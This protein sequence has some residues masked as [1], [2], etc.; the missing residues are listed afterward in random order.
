MSE[1]SPLDEGRPTP[2]A[3]PEEDA[4][5]MEVQPGDTYREGPYLVFTEQFHLR[6]GYCCNSGCRHCP[7]R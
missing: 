5:G 1:E 7:Y 4:S 3:Q 6:R 2:P